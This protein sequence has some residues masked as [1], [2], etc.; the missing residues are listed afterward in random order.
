MSQE[1]KSDTPMTLSCYGSVPQNAAFGNDEIEHFCNMQYLNEDFVFWR[2][3]FNWAV[4]K[5]FPQIQV[6][7]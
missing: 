1:V 4:N 6:T 2:I 3:L 7:L 5:A